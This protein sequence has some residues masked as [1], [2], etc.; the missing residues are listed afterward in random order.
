MGQEREAKLSSVNLG[1]LQPLT[2]MSPVNCKAFITWDLG[3]FIHIHIKRPYSS[4][5]QDL[6]LTA[7]PMLRGVWRDSN[8]P[9]KLE[10]GINPELYSSG[11]ESMEV[12]AIYL[13]HSR[14]MNVVYLLSE[15]YLWINKR[16]YVTLSP[17][18]TTD[19]T[20]TIRFCL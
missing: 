18:G 13:I 6:R 4:K 20:K 11:T 16:H 15:F 14:N 17:S 5:S 7:Q 19:Y 9:L 8:E 2:S 12:T 3:L 1:Q 10:I